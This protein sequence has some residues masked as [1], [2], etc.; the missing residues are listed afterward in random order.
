MVEIK[1]HNRIAK[2]SQEVG[3]L[4]QPIIT[5]ADSRERKSKL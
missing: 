5:P 2:G 4:K 3:I 1:I